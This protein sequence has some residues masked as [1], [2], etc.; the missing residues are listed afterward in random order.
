MKIS[1]PSKPFS[2]HFNTNSI[3]HTHTQPPSSSLQFYAITNRFLHFFRFRRCR[4]LF[5]LISQNFN[6][7]KCNLHVHTIMHTHHFHRLT[8]PQNYFEYI[9]NRLRNDWINFVHCGMVSNIRFF[10]IFLLLNA[11]AFMKCS[12]GHA[13]TGPNE[14]AASNVKSEWVA[15]YFVNK[16]FHH[17][18][19]TTFS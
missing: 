7:C 18:F 8:A 1:R 4:R 19:L 14:I 15:A 17:N 10:P 5:H 2:M 3:I 13:R 12:F 16:K 11:R 9:L 6:I